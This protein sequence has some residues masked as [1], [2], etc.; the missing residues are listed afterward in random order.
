MEG[1]MESK[2]ESKMGHFI[3]LKVFSTLDHHLTF[4]SQ[5]VTHYTCKIQK[6]KNIPEY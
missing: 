4:F 3:F 6:N 1:G 2:G 5:Y